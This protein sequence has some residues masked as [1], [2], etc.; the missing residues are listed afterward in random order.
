MSFIRYDSTEERQQAVMKVVQERQA[1][2]AML[3]GST[4]SMT[5]EP[6]LRAVLQLTTIAPEIRDAV[7][8]EGRDIAVGIRHFNEMKKDAPRFYDVQVELRARFGFWKQAWWTVQRELGLDGRPPVQ[9]LYNLALVR[10]KDTS[11]DEIVINARAILDA[12]KPAAEK[13]P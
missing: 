5:R 10:A 7:L 8:A 3:I 13:A 6:A 2:L 1:E 11:M 4:N 12:L 9:E